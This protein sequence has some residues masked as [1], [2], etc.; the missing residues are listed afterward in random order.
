MALSVL[1]THTVRDNPVAKPSSQPTLAFDKLQ[2]EVLTAHMR[3]EDPLVV[4]ASLVSLR[5]IL[6]SHLSAFS[7]HK[8]GVLSSLG[9]V[10]S[11]YDAGGDSSVSLPIRRDALRCL[12]LILA[13]PSHRVDSLSTQEVARALTQTL[14]DPDP[15]MRELSAAALVAAA[16]GF[17]A[18]RALTSLGFL[19]ALVSQLRAETASGRD[20]GAEAAG[21]AGAAG[22]QL[23]ALVAVLSQPSNGA[24]IA[25]CLAAGAEDC[26]AQTLTAA[27]PGEGASAHRE[28]LSLGLRA[29]GA[30]A[31]DPRGREAC[32]AHPSLLPTIVSLAPPPPAGGASS[33]VEQQAGVSRQALGCLM[34]RGTLRGGTVRK[35]PSTRTAPALCISC[36]PS[37]RVTAPRAASQGR[38][39][40]GASECWS[41]P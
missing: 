11:S 14:S 22:A 27:M 25:A 10:A 31:L 13:S 30:L 18:C 23:Q 24:A 1:S 16:A 28:R 39:R 26:L 12:A 2:Q 8:S 19:A 29:V 41:R 21:S 4:A 3:S 15:L 35:L 37:Q 17:D 32:A 5:R 7:V 40:E 34:V 6:S 36:R 20:G 38:Q 33:S 9:L